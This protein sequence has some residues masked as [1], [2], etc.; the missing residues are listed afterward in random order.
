[1]HLAARVLDPNLRANFQNGA[2]I[3]RGIRRAG[4]FHADLIEE[5]EKY[6]SYITKELRLPRTEEFIF[7]Y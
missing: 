4:D 1:M 7:I 2:A 5:P 3:W 6:A